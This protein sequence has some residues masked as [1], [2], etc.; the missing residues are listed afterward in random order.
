MGGFPAMAETTCSKLASTRK[1][2]EQVPAIA[3]FSQL[4]EH[5]PNLF[6]KPRRLNKVT[7]II[8]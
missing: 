6:F 3:G 8:S 7:G 5:R 2:A 4:I 1:L